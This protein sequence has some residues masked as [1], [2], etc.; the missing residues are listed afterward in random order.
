MPNSKKNKITSPKILVVDDEPGILEFLADLLGTFGYTATAIEGGEQALKQLETETFDVILVDLKM[1]KVNGLEV[2]RKAKTLDPDAVVIFLTGYV[3]LENALEMMRAGGAFDC[4]FKPLEDNQ[5][6]QLVLEKAFSYRRARAEIKQ[7]N[8]E[9]AE[10]HAK[11]REARLLEKKRAT[12]LMTLI[13]VSTLITSSLNL[14]EILDGILRL[15]MDLMSVK[16]GAILLITEQQ[17]LEYVAD[18]GFVEE[19]KY[20]AKM[21]VGE[22]LTGWVAQHGETLSVWDMISD[23]RFKFPE[24]ARKFNLKSYLGVPL[25]MKDKIIGVLNIYTDGSP[26]EFSEDEI[27]LYSSFADQAAIAI[28]HAQLYQKL[29]KCEA[30]S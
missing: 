22:S 5:Y 1:P 20:S 15:C 23:S 21:K 19:V 17:E 30:G 2:L 11:E 4:L 3:T 27:R 28:D 8:K 13:K 14:N 24:F 6:L 16:H 10:M 12:E 9:L 29:K 25:K 18:V 26:R 7:Q